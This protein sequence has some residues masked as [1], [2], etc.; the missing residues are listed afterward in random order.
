MAE[1]IPLAPKL[2]EVSDDLI[3]TAID[4]ELAEGTVRADTVADTPCVFLSGLY[5]AEKVI[6]DRFCAL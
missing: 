1:L 6:A 2:L 3:E 5:H 4:L